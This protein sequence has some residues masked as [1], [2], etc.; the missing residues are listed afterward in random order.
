MKMEDTALFVMSWAFSQ[1]MQNCKGR[2]TL[3]ANGCWIIPIV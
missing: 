2:T 3:R 1:D